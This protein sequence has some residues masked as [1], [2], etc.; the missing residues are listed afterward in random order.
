VAITA[1]LFA[2]LTYAATWCVAVALAGDHTGETFN[3]VV[4]G[5]PLTTLGW[6]IFLW[7]LWGCA[8]FI[9]VRG[10]PE[11]VSKAV[12][13]LLRGSVLELLTPVP[14]HIIVRQ[15]GDCSAP[16]DTGLGIATG[17]SVMLIAFGPG[18]LLLYMKRLHQ[19]KRGATEP[20]VSSV[21]NDNETRDEL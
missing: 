2:L 3:R 8:F 6:W 21:N 4:A 13:W 11:P 18:V 10:H 9:Y 1:W 20:A 16:L 12:S 17:V 5:T 14:S 19:Y 15:R 7:S